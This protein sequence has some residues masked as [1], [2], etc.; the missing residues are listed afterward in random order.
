MTEYLK[1]NKG[2]QFT[3]GA[4]LKSK[5]FPNGQ[6]LVCVEID[7]DTGLFVWENEWHPYEKIKITQD[8]LYDSVWFKHE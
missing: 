1:D 3:V 7:R 2:Q 6:G 4:I 5:D 8:E